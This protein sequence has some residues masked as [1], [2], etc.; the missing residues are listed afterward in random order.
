MAKIEW[1]YS[2]ED[3]IPLPIIKLFLT[4]HIKAGKT[5]LRQH[6]G[7]SEGKPRQSLHQREEK[8][9]ERTA[10]IEI[11]HL[12]HD[13]FGSVVAYDLAGHCEYTTSHSVVIDCGSNSV[14]VILFDITGNLSEMKTQVNYWAA[15]IKAG[16]HKSSIPYV[17]LVATHRDQAL[18]SGKSVADIQRIYSCIFKELEV[19]YDQAFLITHEAFI[20]NCL[21]STSQE[22]NYLRKAI[23][24]SCERIKKV[25]M[26]LL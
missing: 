11:E 25:Q 12:E 23:G 10:G 24:D 18:A 22:M 7:E 15:F 3:T 5:A 20:I 8:L 14:F 17:L 19:G 1:Q 26:V 9:K 13:E 2:A 6:L 4:G 16:R 21:D